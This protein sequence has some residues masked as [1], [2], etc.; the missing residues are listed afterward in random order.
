MNTIPLPSQFYPTEPQK[1]CKKIGSPSYTNTTQT[2]SS[3]FPK[4]SFPSISLNQSQSRSKNLNQTQKHQIFTQ[5]S[6]MT[7]KNENNPFVSVDNIRW[8]NNEGLFTS[9]MELKV[10]Y[11]VTKQ[12]EENI[13]WKVI[14]LGSA[15]S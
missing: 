13:T 4:M 2:H 5:T 3:S 9:E 8:G 1:N 10:Q 14:Y 6:P 11:T 15:Y 7:H 12:L